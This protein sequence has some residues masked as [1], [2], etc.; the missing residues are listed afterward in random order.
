MVVHGLYGSSG[1]A[2]GQ[3]CDQMP[4]IRKDGSGIG[5][6]MFSASVDIVI[7]K[8]VLQLAA[9]VVSPNSGVMVFE[10]AGIGS[11]G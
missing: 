3:S 11:R 10:R 6:N 1:S 4:D 8:S 7:A 5:G 2:I 9:A